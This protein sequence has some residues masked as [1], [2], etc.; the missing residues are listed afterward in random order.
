[1][2][3]PIL[4]KIQTL[5]EEL[6]QHNYN[7]YV[8]DTPSISDYEFDQ[9]LKARVSCFPLLFRKTISSIQ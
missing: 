6:N 8:L 5:R 2:N 9:K 4:E 1:M 7:Y 3:D